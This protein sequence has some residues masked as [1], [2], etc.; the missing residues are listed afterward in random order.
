MMEVQKKWKI[1][2]WAAGG[3]ILLG[4]LFCLVGWIT[5]NNTETLESFGS[6]FVVFGIA[7]IAQ[8]LRLSRNPE[9]M[10][11]REIAERD[12]R[13]QMLWDKARSYAFSIYAPATGVAVLVLYLLHKEAAGMILAGSLCG[14]VLLYVI[15]YIVLKRKY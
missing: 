7:R 15:V 5:G 1:R 13:N 2:L 8:Y 4:A 14:L 11:A 9:Q 6:C 10:E 12:E 3:Y